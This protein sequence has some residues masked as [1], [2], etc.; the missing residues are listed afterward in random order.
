VV[1]VIV[2]RK[3]DNRATGERQRSL[4]LRPPSTGRQE[5]PLSRARIIEAAVAVLDA[6][7]I[8]RLTMRRLAEQLGVGPTT[9]YWHVDT[10]DDVIDL[11]VDA[12]FA[13]TPVPVAP[14]ASWRADL[15]TLLTGWRETLLR[16]PWSAV[17]PSRQRPAV[18]PNFLAWM[19]FLQATLVRA[20]FTGQHVAAAS[21]VL[22]SHVQGSAGS[23]A[24]MRWTAAERRAGQEQLQAHS[25]LY[26]TLAAHDY[27][28][29][30]DWADN[31]VLGLAYILD[32]FEARLSANRS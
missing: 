3:P 26:P 17:L 24:S 11:A 4:W 8:E 31:F 10:K 20:G 12:I 27:L 2:G 23:Q 6:E 22:H 25:D 9:L 29:D 1:S 32:G 30:D 13:E 28:L 14:S 21:W 7:G 5:P 18:G 16:H 15:V 19:E